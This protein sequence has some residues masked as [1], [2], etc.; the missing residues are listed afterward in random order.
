MSSLRF[1]ALEEAISRTPLN[2][3]PPSNRV[4]EFF[5]EN[6]FG[7]DAMQ[8]YVPKGALDAIKEATEKGTSIDRK[9][10][11]EVA[12]AMQT[13]ALERGVTHYTHWFQPLTGATAEKHDVFMDMVDGNAIEKFSGSQLAQQEPDASSFP[14][15]G[16]R[17]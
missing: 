12:I 1:K 14:S 16:I 11:D 15:G 6:V 13:W 7:F 17:N 5:G 2:V 10:A 3:E 9:T 4:S 8:K